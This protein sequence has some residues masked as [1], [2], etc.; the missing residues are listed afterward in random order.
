MSAPPVTRPFAPHGR[1]PRLA[2]AAAGVTVLLWASAFVVIRVI[3]TDI[4]P[5]PMA[6]GRVAVAALA[7]TPFV[8]RRRGLRLPRGRTLALVVVYGVMWFAAYN[9]ALNAAERSI[10]AGTAALVVNVAPILIAVGAAVLLKEGFSLPLLGG[11]VVALAGVALMSAG[12]GSGSG[13]DGEPVG[14]LLALLAA[15]LYAASVLI[16]KR[17]LGRID[18]LTVTWFGCVVG[19]VVLLPFAPA[20]AAEAGRAPGSAV[21]GTVYLGLFPTAVAFT[22]WAYALTHVPAGRLGVIGYVVTV[23]AVLLSWAL[24]GEVPTGL[25]LAGGAL[26]LVGVAVSRLPDRRASTG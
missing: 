13:G 14:L 16:Q 8:L 19:T 7:L 4:G 12:S 25:V 6:L 11:C 2:V 17:L 3:G 21:L 26:C 10:D 20:L 23:V 9:V 22:T 15:V 24:L 5:G 1:A 18:A